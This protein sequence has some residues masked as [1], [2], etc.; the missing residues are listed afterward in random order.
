MVLYKTNNTMF[1]YILKKPLELKIMRDNP[2]L[3]FKKEKLSKTLKTESSF[4]GFD[5]LPRDK[6]EN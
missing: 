2:A 4:Q 1:F 6:E 5:L 3:L